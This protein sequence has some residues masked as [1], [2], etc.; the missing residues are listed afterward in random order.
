MTEATE[1][2]HGRIIPIPIEDEVKRSYIDYA[3]SVIVSRALPDVRD[4]LKPVHRRILYGMREEGMTPDK[5]YKK[6]AR[7]VGQVLARYHPHG[8]VAVYDAV[9]RMAQ[10]FAIRYPL[11]DGHGNFGSLDGDPPAAMRYTE[12]RL[13]PL[14]MEMLRDIDKETV[15]FVPNFDES[16]TE[17]TVLP[18]RFPNLLV[19]G[20]AGI[21]VG[22]AT[23]IP[24]HNLGEV[25]DALVVMIDDPEATD[26]KKV[27]SIVRGPDFPTGAYILG[28]DGIRQ[29]YT[30]GRGLITIRAKTQIETM[31]GGKVRIVISEI[32]YQVNK[33]TLIERIAELVRDKKIEGV[34]DLRDESDRHGVRIVIDLRREVNANVILNRL[35]KYTQ[36]QE[37]FGIIL[38]ALV[39][40]RPQVLNLKEC[41]DHYLTYQKEIIVRRTKFELARAEARAHILEGLL[42]ALN[43]LDAVIKLIRSSKDPD[44]ARDG[45][46][47]EFKLTEK[48]AQAILDMRLQ[49]LTAL[50]RDKIEEEY[51]E[52]SRQIEYFRAVLG[53]ERMV[54]QIVRRELLEIREKYAD[55]RRTVITSAAV[56]QDFDVEDLIAEEDV[57]VTMTHQGYVKR[58]PP[59]TYR[60]QRRGGR[61][62]T[63]MGTKEEDFVE[64][65]FVTTTHH[66]LL[67]FSNKGRAYRLRAHEI[68]EASRTAKGTAVINL[69]PV[70]PGEII[71]AVIAVKDFDPDLYL[72]MATRRGTVKRTQLSEFDTARSSGLV[73][74]A[75]DEGDELIGVRLAAAGEEII[76]ATKEGKAIRFAVEEVRPMG[77]P[78]RGVKGI[79]LDSGDEVV[80]MDPVNPGADLLTVTTR[81][82]GKRTP[83]SDYPTRKR[84]GKGVINFRLSPKTGEVVGVR[85]VT[86]GDEV[87]VISAKGTLIRVPVDQIRVSGRN[88]Q[89][90]SVMKPEEGDAVVTLSRVVSK[91][92]G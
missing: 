77:R 22:M 10:D 20:A 45:L 91:D 2:T 33:A 36:M 84:G 63:G 59:D 65:L 89:G 13:T 57:V 6:S 41:L 92:E 30:T 90:V 7:V 81:G 47:R 50:E 14:A 52:L 62:V 51:Q 28:R 32:P 85:T 88:T 48:Q 66:Y 61:G 78:A 35:F 69:V 58:L 46:M 68:P 60:L 74:L 3:M 19:N 73:A 43:N 54:L 16:E 21:A 18:A 67:F 9:V 40:G 39:N 34:S 15:D 11:V 25:I 64:H 37:T 17:P 38:L 26:L 75:L 55:A 83:V 42:V 49:R 76:L 27:M 5:P 1:H 24:P 80:S 4:G 79:T 70:A 31:S 44:T 56:N 86:P 23:N 12:V 53:S 8:D 72:F 29:A 82:F 87:M 71:S